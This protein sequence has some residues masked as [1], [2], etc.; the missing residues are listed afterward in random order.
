MFIR[1]F[2]PLLVASLVAAPL[3]ANENWVARSNEHAQILLDVLARQSPEAASQFGVGDRFD[4][5]VFQ[6]PPDYHAR[7]IAMLQ[8]A[9][10]KL[11][12]KRAEEKDPRVQQDLEIMIDSAKH[13]IK[14]IRLSEKYDL[15][16][17][18]LPQSLFHGI[19]GLLDDQVPAQRRAAALVRLNKYGGMEKGYTPVAQQAIA[20]IKPGLRS[21]ALQGPFIGELEKN[22]GNSARYVAGI[23]ELF[24]K[25]KIKG[26]EKP[27]AALKMQ[28]ADYEAFVRAEILPRARADFRLP[29]EVYRYRLETSGIDLPVEE[30][31]SRA[32]T[33]FREIQNE[34]DSVARL[35]AKEKGY[36][37]S[38][39]RAVIRELKKQQLVGDAILPHYEKRI[40]EL[41]KLIAAGRVV[42]I[43]SRPMK[44]RLASEAESAAT[45]APNMRP[46]RLIGNTGEVGEFVLPLR[47][48][49]EKGSGDTGFDD[50]TFDAASWTLTVH[51]G[52]PGHELQFTSLV[53]KGVSLPRVFFAFN[54]VNVEGWAL[55]MEAEMKPML[56]LDGQLISLQHRLMRAARAFLDPGL[57]LGK[58]TREEAFRVLEEDVVLS[59]AMAMQEVER[60]T[61]WAPGQAPSYFYGSQRWME[62]RTDAERILGRAFDRQSYHDFALAQGIL[63]PSLMRQAVMEEYIAPRMAKPAP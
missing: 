33:S 5:E 40:A 49:G 45:P 23:G 34:M 59:H 43:P 36:A 58:L 12:A 60:Y 50:F 21:A 32:K 15:Q 26:Y 27:Y 42:T 48:P 18:D 61:F 4:T 20:F 13:Q 63:S 30:L 19:R 46:P 8:E 37:S 53:E 47:I 38:D 57:Q 54:S 3:V 44:I 31:V 39:Y 10:A 7:N 9:V 11:E 55:Y 51:E 29:E 14:G 35:V 24:A 2:L 22:L 1:R 62:L 41:E 16:Y 17:F 52:R 56:P 6:L 25:Y 28:L